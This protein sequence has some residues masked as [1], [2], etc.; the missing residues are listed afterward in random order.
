[1]FLKS[2]LILKKDYTFTFDVK[3]YLVIN[4]SIAKSKEV[5]FKAQLETKIDGFLGKYMSMNTNS[6]NLRIS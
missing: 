5:K 2:Y 3:I 6:L 1:M 4:I